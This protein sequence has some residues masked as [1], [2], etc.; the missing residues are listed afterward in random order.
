MKVSLAYSSIEAP[1]LNG[2][3]TYDRDCAALA[4]ANE[5]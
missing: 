5:L 3:R 4:L 1:V 2:N